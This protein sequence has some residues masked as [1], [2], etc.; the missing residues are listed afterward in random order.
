MNPRAIGTKYSC[1][2]GLF[3][4]ALAC[5]LKADRLVCRGS[6]AAIDILFADITTIAVFRERRFGS[7][8]SYRA[9]TIEAGGKEFKLTAAHR[10]GL[11]RTQDRTGFFI[12][13]VKAFT[14]RALAHNPS[15]RFI[16]A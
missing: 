16:D 1:R 3:R 5:E 9:C 10:A 6:T 4:P 14:R 8:R 15:I 11:L 13:F 2:P 12:P 7:S